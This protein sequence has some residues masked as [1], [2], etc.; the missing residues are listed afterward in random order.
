MTSPHNQ[1]N[2]PC[3]YGDAA[4]LRDRL[5]EAGP[6]APPIPINFWCLTDGG[7]SSPSEETKALC[8]DFSRKRK[9]KEAASLEEK[10]LGFKGVGI[11]VKDGRGEGHRKFV[12]PGG[13]ETAVR[14]TTFGAAGD[15]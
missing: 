9:A 14:E 4:K 10:A 2:L 3:R 11:E 15:P 13:V 12:L 7:S 8:N 1:S 6:P 5:A